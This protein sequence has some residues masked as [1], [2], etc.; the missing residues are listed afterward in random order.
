MS[1]TSFLY[2][3][4]A[5]AAQT[6]SPY[7]SSTLTLNTQKPLQKAFIKALG[8]PILSPQT[9]CIILQQ[10]GNIE[11]LRA[12]YTRFND[13]SRNASE[14]QKLKVALFKT[15]VLNLSVSTFALDK[16][17]RQREQQITVYEQNLIDKDGKNILHDDYIKDLIGLEKSQLLLATRGVIDGFD[18]FYDQSPE[19]VKTAF[20]SALKEHKKE[21]VFDLAQ[22]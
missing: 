11:Q 4:A 5:Q 16:A 12:A 21:T 6:P 8:N 17:S 14:A 18:L 9:K 13:L 3:S 15:K 1:S 7:Q 10:F 20:N 19:P 2:A 22:E